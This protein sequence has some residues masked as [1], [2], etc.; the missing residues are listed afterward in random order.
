M[1][2]K[3]FSRLSKALQKNK[4]APADSMS[5][6]RV[7]TLIKD[8]YRLEAEVGRGGMGVVYRA[9][10]LSNDRDVVLKI[11]NLENANALARKQF[12]QEIEIHAAL[13]HPHIVAVYETGTIEIGAQEPSLF[14]VMEWL[15]G[16][17][18]DG[19]R[20]LTY[21]K[22][23]EIGKQVC[24][25]LE[26]IHKQGFVYR[27]L[28]PGNILLEVRGFRYF[29]KLTDFG[30]AR[31]RG[32]AYL[33]NESSLAGTPFYLA[34]EL[35]AGEPPDVASDLYAL[36]ATLYELIT[37][38]PPFFDFDEKTILLQHQESFVA[39]PSQS[40]A[41]VPAALEAIVLR[42]LAKNSQDRFASA[43]E[44]YDALEQ[45]V[46]GRAS[47]SSGGNL[48]QPS[49]D[50]HEHTNELPQL[51]KMIEANRLV[52]VLGDA[53]G[54]ALAVGNQLTAQFQDGVWWVNLESVSDPTRV[55]D[56]VASVFGICSDPPRSLAV[57]LIED[58]HEKNLLILLNHCEHLVGACAQLADTLLS[59]CP[60]VYI[61]AISQ[62]PL[63]LAL[64][65]R[66]LP[67]NPFHLGNQ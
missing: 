46:V 43:Q 36:G 67:A 55:L 25:A 63:N 8:R 30:L 32:V 18:L 19:L 49:V 44:V 20:R 5:S 37:G 14:L 10:D 2:F 57:S 59:T 61:L 54:L 47:N 50:L 65:A 40:R 60:D 6:L 7:G 51:T 52:T 29:V 39:P 42:L 33:E 24:E 15:S 12:L 53:D 34:P 35:I 16:P 9:R 3:F 11:V 38:R 58:L 13:H 31:P 28:K 23:L 56:M 21:T 22:I 66:Y 4:T 62:Q 1:A 64:E 17:S 41:D 26:Y 27:D 45:I 48:P